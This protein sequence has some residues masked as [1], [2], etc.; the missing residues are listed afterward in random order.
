MNRKQESKRSMFIVVE[1]FV[2]NSD[3][4]VLALM[5][6]FN[7]EY[8]DF[9]TALNDLRAASEDQLYNRTGARVE[10]EL[11]QTAM[12]DLSM[13][14]ASRIRAYAYDSGN[15]FLFRKVNK[16]RSSI[17]KMK[18]SLSM[19]YCQMVHD[20]GTALLA[21]LGAYGVV[22]Q[23]LTDLQ[24]AITVY[25][26][27]L[28]KPR[29]AIVDRRV[30]TELVSQYLGV[31][32]AKVAAMDVH[33]KML[34]WSH[35]EF[36]ERYTFSRKLVTPGYRKLSL[37]GTI[38]NE[39]GEALAGAVVRIGSLG[40]SKRSTGNGNYE[41]KSLPAGVYNVSFELQGYETHTQ[42]VA[43]VANERTDVNVQLH[44][45]VSMRIAS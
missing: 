28:P 40:V 38:T 15:W 33:V 4:S 31:C 42:P 30:Q 16:S 3:A 8:Q 32:S 12:V 44:E 34:E 18:D 17:A 27:W 2:Q 14:I 7:S 37:R 13:N 36:Y 29:T 6:N 10:K 45:G 5:P 21:S 24:A 23:D 26:E 43:I 39:M 19:D 20:E 35:P 1:E 41:F 22:A 11:L 25:M 9:V